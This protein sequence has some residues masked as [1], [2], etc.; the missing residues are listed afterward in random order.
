MNSKIFFL[1]CCILLIVRSNVSAQEKQAFWDTTKSDEKRADIALKQLTLDEK[2]KMLTGGGPSEFEGVQRLGIPNM[3]CSDGPRGPHGPVGYP[4]GI[5]MAS[6]FNPDLIGEEAVAMGKECRSRGIGMLLGPAININRDPLGA[7]FFEYLTEDPY[8][9][10]KITVDFVKGIQS[11]HVSACIK[12][13]ACNNRDENRNLYMS[14]V[15]ERTLHEI[16]FPAFKAGVKEGH[17]FGLMTAANGLN[18]DLCSDSQHLL[19]DILKKTWK[20]E[21]FVLTDW[22]QS[23]STDKAA[24]AGLDVSMPYSGNSLFGK[25]LL[26]EVKSG[27]IPE[28]IINDKVS[29][30][31]KVMAWAGNLNEGGIKSDGKIDLEANKKIALK[32]AEEGVVLLKNDRNILPLDK[33]KSKKIIVLGPNANQK[34]CVIGLGGSSWVD[35]PDEVTILNGIKSYADE[36]T[37]VKYFPMDELNG[38]Q[39][40]NPK[41]LKINNDKN[42]FNAKYFNGGLDTKPLIERTEKNV[43]FDWEMRSPDINK[44]STDNFSAQFSTEII[45]PVTGTYML[46]IK[47]DNS[48]WLFVDREGGAPIAV[49]DKSK[50]IDEATAT[51]QMEKG[52]PFFIR[53]DYHK[54]TGDA[55]CR[56]DWQMPVNESVVKDTYRKLDNEIIDAT[57]VVFVGGI[58][59][60]LDSEGRDRLNINFPRSQEKI[61]DHI[62]TKNKNTIVV[63]VNGSPLEVGGWIKHV[64]AVLESWYNGSEA[65]T[66]IAKILFGDIN[67]SARLPFTWPQKLEDSPSHSIGTENRDFVY[68]KEGVFTGY[69]YY[70]SKKIKPEF[71]F[72]YGLSYTSFQYTDLQVSKSDNGSVI[73]SVDVKNTGNQFGADVVQLYIH[74]KTPAIERPI[75]ELKGFQKVYLN[76]GESKRITFKLDPVD[77]AFYDVKAKA[78]NVENGDYEI[79]IGKSCADIKLSNTIKMNSQLIED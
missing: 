71:S 12:H 75:R 68:Y 36:T 37:E 49:C 57:A 51:V 65:G 73:A 63:L 29:R 58:D 64:P 42:G 60:S 10:S 45:P 16:Y 53:I 13:F 24:L 78:W 43:D 20:F 48:A 3:V 40:I 44:I 67:P 77:F 70:L 50:G 55:N 4:S 27:K 30:I 19:N 76:P 5:S 21:G 31:L 17:A 8:L 62:S 52:K 2:I 1:C 41:Y 56:L 14:I 26:E 69:R 23:R 18:N 38:F 46:R 25:P 6:T 72:G 33:K 9:N 54:N 59:H 35:S 79:Q 47:A 11:Q 32:S 7:R 34:F 66:A 61:I 39:L 15:D 22:C 28:D 74:E